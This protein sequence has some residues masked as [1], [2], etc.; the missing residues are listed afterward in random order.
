MSASRLGSAEDL[1]L[2]G[3]VGANAHASEAV[4]NCETVCLG[5][6][7]AQAGMPQTGA[8]K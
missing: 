2:A 6:V 7:L 8:H 1:G 4:E 5:T 3:E